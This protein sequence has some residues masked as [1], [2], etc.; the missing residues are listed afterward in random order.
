MD[1]LTRR[2]AIK[3]GAAATLTASMGVADALAQPAAFFTREEFALVDELSEMIVPADEH[4]GGARAANVAAYIDARLA[5]SQDEARKKLWR[6]GL[7]AFPQSSPERLAVLTRMA[8]N[9]AKPRT[10]EDKFFVELKAS[11][12]RVYYTSRVGIRDEMEYK[13][14]SAHAEFTGFDVTED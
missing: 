3:L 2:D 14:N 4:S 10:A 7:K 5:E 8:R 9:E 1:D 6:E 13:G 11:V 12:V